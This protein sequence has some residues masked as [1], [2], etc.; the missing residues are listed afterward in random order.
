MKKTMKTIAI[1]A[2]MFGTLTGHATESYF[3]SDPKIKATTI[4]HFS[5]VK[6]GNLLTIKSFNDEIVHREIIDRNGNYTKKF[7]LSLLDNGDYY[8]EL[9][10]DFEIIL[11]PFSIQENRVIFDMENQKS[12]YKPVLRTKNNKVLIN[13]LSLDSQSL[14]IDLYYGDEL[15]YSEELPAEKIIERA[16]S[17]SNQHKGSYRAVLKSG[18]RIYTKSF[19]I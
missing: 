3:G 16:Y 4:L 5:D 14:E 11:R 12:I 18:N 10:K 15:I 7:D 6:Q 13:M 8:I 9:D 2:L 17:L 19:T 1:L